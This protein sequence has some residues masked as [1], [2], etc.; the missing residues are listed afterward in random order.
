[1]TKTD[2]AFE[3]FFLRTQAIHKGLTDILSLAAGI[4][5]KGEDTVFLEK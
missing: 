1:M 3:C 2:V 5:E 4:S